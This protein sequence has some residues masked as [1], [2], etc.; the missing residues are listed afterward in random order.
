MTG[1][2]SYPRDQEQRSDLMFAYELPDHDRTHNQH[3]TATGIGGSLGGTVVH[4]FT[5]PVIA[6]TR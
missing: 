1:E 3:A 5:I 4:A 2:Y 6:A